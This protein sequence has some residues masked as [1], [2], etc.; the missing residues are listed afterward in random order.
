MANTTL[1]NCQRIVIV[2]Q[3]ATLVLVTT[4]LTIKLIKK[5][6]DFKHHT[7]EQEP[8]SES[9]ADK[10]KESSEVTNIQFDK[11]AIV[12]TVLKDE[13]TCT[14]RLMKKM[15]ELNSFFNPLLIAM[16]LNFVLG[17]SIVLIYRSGSLVALDWRILQ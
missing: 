4:F 17:R 2:M 15:C 13:D 14:E 6:I 10:Y 8:P 7:K 3:F 12:S 1:Q 11:A 16:P 5:Q 9:A